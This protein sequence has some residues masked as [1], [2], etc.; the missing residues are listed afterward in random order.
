MR[1]AI[2]ALF[3]AVG[4]TA[5][6]VAPAQAI[7]EGGS[8][9]QVQAQVYAQ[10][11]GGYCQI[12]GK[13]IINWSK[14]PK[15]KGLTV[16]HYL[17]VKV[18]IQSPGGYGGTLWNTLAK[19]TFKSKTVNLGQPTGSGITTTAVYNVT[20]GYSEYRTKV[21][22]RVIRNVKPGFDTTAWKRTVV[23][24]TIG[25]GLTSVCTPRNGR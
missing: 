11:V 16:G 17:R 21:T 14:H 13:G 5:A 19:E 20:S 2:F 15:K 23:T 24:D 1:R 25:G 7:P 22:S 18:E 3:T 10:P 6:L 4:V 12:V 9:H 8:K